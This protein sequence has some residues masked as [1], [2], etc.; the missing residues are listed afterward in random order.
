MHESLVHQSSPLHLPT[1]GRPVVVQVTDLVQHPG[2]HAPVKG[3]SFP[4]GAK[5]WGLPGPNGAGKSTT[6]KKSS[7]SKKCRALGPGRLRC[8]KIRPRRATWSS[9]AVLQDT[10]SGTPSLCF[11]MIDEPTLGVDPRSRENIFDTIEKQRRRHHHPLYHAFHGGCSAAL[12]PHC[13]YAQRQDHH[14]GYAAT[15][16]LAPRD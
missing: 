15:R 13:D 16:C 4:I 10:V 6:I 12:Q 2:K 14:G 5:F 1:D 7:G 11:L 3:V 8:I 9:S